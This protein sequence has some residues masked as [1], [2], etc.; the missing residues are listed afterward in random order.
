MA[1]AR[2]VL[3][4]SVRR[5]IILAKFRDLNF[6]LMPEMRCYSIVSVA[7]IVIIS[8]IL[9][10][11]RAPKYRDGPADRTRDEPHRKGYERSKGTG[12]GIDVGAKQGVKDERRR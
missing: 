5:P 10:P 3:D 4:V 9:R 2:W 12:Q 1:V 7:N 11:T 8:M 6:R